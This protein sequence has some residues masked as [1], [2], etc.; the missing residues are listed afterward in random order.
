MAGIESHVRKGVN[1]HF[2][3]TKRREKGME[4]GYY[5]ADRKTK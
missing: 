5:S 1:M 3:K 2:L 4:S